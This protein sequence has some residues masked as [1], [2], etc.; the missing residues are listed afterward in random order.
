MFDKEFHFALVLILACVLAACSSDDPAPTQ[1]PET[2]ASPTFDPPA[3]DY[4]AVQAVT[5]DCPT[6]AAEIYYTLDGTD[7]DETSN[8]YTAPST[9]DVAVSTTIKARAYKTGMT[10]SAITTGDFAIDFP[11]V[12]EPVITPAAGVFSNGQQVDITCSSVGATIYYT[13]DGSDPTEASSPYTLPFQVNSTTAVKA[14]AYAADMDPSPIA[15]ELLVILGGLVAYYPFNGDAQDASGNGHT[16]TVFG[17]VGAED[18][19]GSGNGALQFDG[20]DDYVELSDEASFDFTE[21]T[22]TAWVRFDVLP[23]NP[24]PGLPGFY[25]LVNKGASVGNYAFRLIHRGGAS[26][27]NLNYAH[28]TAVGSWSSGSSPTDIDH[29]TW[30]H[31]AVAVAGEVS[32]YVDG[33]LDFTSTGMS[34][35]V[36]DNDNVLIGKRYHPTDEHFLNGF[37]DDVRFY[38]RALSET[39]IRMLFEAEN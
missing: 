4:T 9:I 16:G 27:C 10:A 12:A 7:P 31:V 17:A 22:I 30:Y 1:V 20:V 14:R 33:T 8:L 34:A 36:L 26:Y 6:S 23:V 37:L 3:G 35:M 32:F 25:T 21:F 39:E 29:S 38:D 11:D 13:L 5:I 19:R 24:G 15:E 2:V 28:R 18:R